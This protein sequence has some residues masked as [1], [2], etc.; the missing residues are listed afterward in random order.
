MSVNRYEEQIVIYPYNRL[1]LSNKKEHTTQQHGWVSTRMDFKS[2]MLS[3]E[4][5]KQYILYD[6]FIWNSRKV[7][8]VCS[9][10][11]QITSWTVFVGWKG[12]DYKSTLE[13]FLGDRNTLH[14]DGTVKTLQLTIVSKLLNLP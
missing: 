9:H 10:R 13:T 7:K 11:K 6:L 12:T 5:Q 3:E 2:I 14:L 8:S 1:V 4:D